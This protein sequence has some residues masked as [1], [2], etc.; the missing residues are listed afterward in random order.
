MVKKTNKQLL[1]CP[2]PVNTAD[3]VKMA[4]VLNEIGHREKEFEQLMQR[5]QAKLL[6]V[7]QIRRKKAYVPVVITGSGTAANEAVLSSIV[8]KKHILVLSNGEFGERLFAISSVHNS[9]TKHI[10]FDWGTRIEVAKVENYLKTHRVD[11]IAMVHHETS[12]GM[13]NPAYA[14]GQLAAKHNLLFILD[15]VSSAGAEKIDL[16]KWNV[17]FCTTSASKSLGSLP[18]LSLII[19]KREE[20][21]KLKDIPAR[22]MYLNLYKFYEYAVNLRQT[23]NTPAVQLFFALEQAAD[24]ILAQGISFHLAQRKHL[25]ETMRRGLSQLGLTFLIDEKDMSSA[26]TTVVVPNT[27]PVAAL[28]EELRKKNI[29]VYDGKGPFKGKVFQVA[30]IGEINEKD[31]AFFLRTLKMILHTYSTASK[32]AHPFAASLARLSSPALAV[33]KAS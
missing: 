1:L 4:V 21:E 33:Q 20:F 9:H 13:L 12:S 22:T 23:P 14:I 6:A 17:S 19:G 3:N 10:R 30:T 2:G 25:A 8:G 28:K 31:I 15:T 32:K 27:L 29:I 11:I 5:L 7:F 26:L 16:E 18:G 24:N